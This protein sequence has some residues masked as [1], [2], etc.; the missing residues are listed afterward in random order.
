MMTL[1]STG[2]PQ[3]V[4]VIPSSADESAEAE[5]QSASSINSSLIGDHPQSD[6]LYLH[7]RVCQLSYGSVHGFRKHFRN[8]HNYTPTSDDVLIQSISA[9]RQF[10]SA[11]ERTGQV[12]RFYCQQC[13]LQFE[14]SKR[15]VFLQHKITHE[16]PN[17]GVF[18]CAHCLQD[19]AT[20]IL[21]LKHLA[22]RHAD[23]SLYH[24]A[25]VF[26]DLTFLHEN[27]LMTHQAQN[28][29]LSQQSNDD[30]YHLPL[31]TDVKKG[32]KPCQSV[33]FSTNLP[34]NSTT[35]AEP[36]SFTDSNITS[37]KVPVMGSVSV[38]TAAA[39]HPKPDSSSTPIHINLLSIL[40]RVVEEGLR[41]SG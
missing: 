26:C 41:N 23:L 31:V 30:T 33:T 25:C 34:I 15:E 2:T 22:Q 17:R 16:G 38:S 24:Y 36:W 18:R 29:R 10:I 13:G 28:H 11:Q 35:P 32:Q 14:Q 3:S 21:L 20:P 12:P 6:I 9:T 1:L 39:N 37:T 5:R 7:C 19:Q 40:N 27:P 8:M 4:A